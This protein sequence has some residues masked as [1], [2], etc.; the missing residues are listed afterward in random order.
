MEYQF[1]KGNA[2][3]GSEARLQMLQ[4]QKEQN[5]EQGKT[6]LFADTIAVRIAETNVEL[7]RFNETLANTTFDAVKDGFKGMVNAMTDGTKSMGDAFLGFLGGI[8]SA[9]HEQLLD[10]ATKQIT[11]GIFEMM[12]M[13]SISQN[14]SG[15]L[16]KGFS[17][18][19]S[20]GGA[21]QTPAMLTSG[22]YVVRKKIVDRL[23]VSALDKINKGGSVDGSLESLY[24]Q[25]NENSF[26]MSTSGSATLPP[27]VRFNESGHLNNLISKI[28]TPIVQLNSGGMANPFAAR[29]SDSAAMKISKGAGYLAG[30]MAANYSDRDKS[31][32][33]GP[34]KPRHPNET[35]LNTM[36]ALNIDPTGR[37]MTARYRKNDDYSKQYGDY[38]L[39]KYQHD[40]DQR[41]QKM[42]E[43]AS[44]AKGIMGSITGSLVSAG[45]AKGVQA[46]SNFNKVVGFNPMGWNKEDMGNR[47]QSYIDKKG[48]TGENFQSKDASLY[49]FSR[50]GHNALARMDMYG[51]KTKFGGVSGH[52]NTE[53]NKEDWSQLNQKGYV[54]KAFDKDFRSDPNAMSTKLANSNKKSFEDIKH[55]WNAN[56]PIQPMDMTPNMT[57][58]YEK[59]SA[60]GRVEG[61]GGIDQV[62]PVMLDKGE[63]VIRASSVNNIEKK[64]PG[65]FDRLNSMKMNQGGPVTAAPP[66]T[67]A[68]AE[69]STTQNSSSNVTV[70]INISSGGQASVE[71]GGGGDQAFASKIKDAVVGV[72]AQ[73]KRVG[74]MLSG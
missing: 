4:L 35:R 47:A 65:F 53:Y 28:S 61:P 29:E 58:S 60:G 19:G 68:E 38:L 18:G 3:K 24:Q 15:G 32:N 16:I 52:R 26:D 40:V 10:R 33:S 13:D 74:G 51:T 70:N 7:E 55:T 20:T 45:V 64:Y 50:E 5:I 42:D 67:T 48:I 73:E 17:Q 1:G 71:G 11:S 21:R 62:G 2:L 59:L 8:A 66:A 46:L 37:Q 43:R 31:S 72:I 57:F 34:E 22:E 27:M 25:S 39:A 12:G 56:N 54:Q 44:M 6:G 36:S 14:N 41:N 30:S 9:I 63:Y 23:G 49:N 69:T